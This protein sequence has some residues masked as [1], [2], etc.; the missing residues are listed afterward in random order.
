[1]RYEYLLCSILPCFF[2]QISFK[3]YRFH[4]SSGGAHD[5]GVVEHAHE[6]DVE[7]QSASDVIIGSDFALDLNNNHIDEDQATSDHVAKCVPQDIVEAGVVAEADH[8]D[9]SEQLNQ[10]ANK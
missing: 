10:A 9:D 4:S 7:H 6:I 2:I 1:M 8:A 3:L 5:Q